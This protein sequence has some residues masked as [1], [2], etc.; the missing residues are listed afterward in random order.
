MSVQFDSVALRG[1]QQ[2]ILP[3]SDETQ[4]V[5]PQAAAPSPAAGAVADG[6]PYDTK[7]LGP[8]ASAPNRSLYNT[9]DGKPDF[10]NQKGQPS[11]NDL[12][13]NGY[14]DCY[15]LASIASLAQ[16]H[17]GDIKSMIQDN[18]NGTFTV[19]FPHQKDN[20][21]TNA[22]GLFGDRYHDVKVTVSDK[23]LPSNAVNADG[24][25]SGEKGT[26]KWPE[27]LEAAYAKTHGGYDAIG[28]GGDPAKAMEQITGKPAHGYS[29][30]DGAGKI[31]QALKD[32][33]MVTVSTPEKVG[34]QDT[35]DKN[36][37]KLIGG[38]AYT[39]TG[40]V[41]ENGKQFVELRNPW[42]FD[43]PERISLDDLAKDGSIDGVQIGDT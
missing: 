6:P 16:S 28:K 33:K 1:P 12:N 41:T 3:E 13:Q 8:D 27:V 5:Q 37:H 21:I 14:G 31:E 19:T 4:A 35:Y 40:I 42:G 23:D 20:G 10:T 26:P 25:P 24:A 11:V 18:G 17:P 2:H 22:W 39:V 32:G 29:A 30:G 36:A 9:P 7:K 34:G 15:F 38:H 43:Q